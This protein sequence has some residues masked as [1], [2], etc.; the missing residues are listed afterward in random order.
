MLKFIQLE[1]RI[2][3]FAFNSLHNGDLQIIKSEQIS[4]ENES[5]QMLP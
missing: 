5:L 1:M 4:G 2:Y 3:L